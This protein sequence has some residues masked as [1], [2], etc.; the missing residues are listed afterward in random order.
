MSTASPSTIVHDVAMFL[1]Y[2]P[3]PEAAGRGEWERAR[4]A[5]AQLANSQCAA[6]SPPPAPLPPPPNVVRLFPPRGQ[7]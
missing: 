3:H 4:A 6:A 2:P 7:T 1:L 5:I